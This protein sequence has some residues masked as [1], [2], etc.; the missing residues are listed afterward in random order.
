MGYI[1]SCELGWKWIWNIL[2]PESSPPWGTKIVHKSEERTMFNDIW[3]YYSRFT[4]QL[5]HFCSYSH[6]TVPTYLCQILIQPVL[7]CHGAPLLSKEWTYLL[8]TNCVLIH[9]S[10]YSP[11]KVLLNSFREMFAKNY[12]AQLFWGNYWGIC[13]NEVIYLSALF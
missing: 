1:C 5:W 11:R 8:G 13:K 6:S 3:W 2:H 10:K 4:V 7:L 9:R 12:S